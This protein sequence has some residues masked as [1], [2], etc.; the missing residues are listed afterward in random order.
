MKRHIELGIAGVFCWLLA[1][2]IDSYSHGLL[3]AFCVVAGLALL[4]PAVWIYGWRLIGVAVR[5]ARSEV[6]KH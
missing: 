2:T 3:W 6:E 4:V 5:V 1:S